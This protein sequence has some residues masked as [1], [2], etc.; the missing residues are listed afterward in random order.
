MN[1]LWITYED[2]NGD[3][4]RVPAR[5]EVCGRCH[6]KGTHVNPSIDGHG[7]SA[8]DECWDDEQFTEMYFG[9]GYDVACSECGGQRVVLEPDEQDAQAEVL[10]A[11]Y[12]HRDEID[13]IDRMWEMEMRYGA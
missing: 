2:A 8:G 6:G 1:G 4:V 3:E 12:E 10:D 7:I 9:G 5:Y 13:A 11:Y